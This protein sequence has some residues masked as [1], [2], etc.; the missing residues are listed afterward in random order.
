MFVGAGILTYGC[1]GDDVFEEFEEEEEIRSLAKRSMQY[2]GE[3]LRPS[4]GSSKVKAGKW[5]E[6]V[7]CPH[8]EVK[9]NVTWTSGYT[10]G[11]HNENELAKITGTVS[12]SDTIIIYP[13][14]SHL[15]WEGAYHIGGELTYDYAKWEYVVDN[16]GYV[17]LQKKI[18]Y[19]QKY[20]FHLSNPIKF[21][22]EKEDN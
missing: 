14:I 3:G 11:V 7:K 4:T 22:D 6:K 13:R 9:I 16:R 21:E 10:S 1:S 18:Y 5:E 15:D 12:P 19:N 2:S 20:V 17:K 8:G